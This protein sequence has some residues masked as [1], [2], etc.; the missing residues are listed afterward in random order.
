[1]EELS[2]VLAREDGVQE[3]LWQ[4]RDLEVS[5]MWEDDVV[6]VGAGTVAFG[7]RCKGGA[8]MTLMTGDRGVSELLR[9]RASRETPTPP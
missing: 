9:G 8:T 7:L 1:M 5:I 3:D 2:E 4:A 6:A